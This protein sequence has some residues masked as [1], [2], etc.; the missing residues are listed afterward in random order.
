MRKWNDIY[1][2]IFKKYTLG[3]QIWDKKNLEKAWKQVRANK[4]SAGI[5]G[6]TIEE[7][8]QNLEQNLSEIQRQLKENHYVPNPVKRVLIPKDNGKMRQL[9]VP[10]V[11]DRVVQQALKNVLEPIFEKIFLPQSHGYRPNT[12]AHA[13]VRKAE[14]F[15]NSGYYWV[16]DADIKGFFDH[17]DHK[18]LMDLV[19]EQVSDGRVLSWI[20]SI[21]K[22]GIMNE[23]VFEE[24]TEGTPQGG[25]ISPLLANIYLNHFDRRM[26]EYGYLL[27]RYADDIIIFCKH[28]WE[29]EDALKRAKEILERELK[30]ELSP[31]K[32]KIV[33]GNVT[34]VEFLGFHFNGRWKKPKDKA[35]KKFKSEIK[36]RTRRKI[37][38]SLETVIKLLNPVIRGWWNYFKGCTKARIFKELDEYIADR[39][40]CFKA[41]HRSNKVLWYSLPKHE[42]AKMGLAVMYHSIYE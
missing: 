15:I 21:L 4:G 24:S 26:G 13:A 16:V 27:L 35:V 1:H 10:T 14:A 18:I 12:N 23:G 39:L 17:V 2:A 31:E 30:L 37:P 40:R 3:N 22:S 34:G 33:H 41:K 29:A 28:E 6:V 9:G 42:L 36:K 20:E 5:D 19:C 25:N 8:E 7:F 32:T 11:K 38:I